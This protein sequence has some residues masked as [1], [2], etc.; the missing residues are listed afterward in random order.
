AWSGVVLAALGA[1]GAHV[2]RYRTSRTGP[3]SL[4]LLG[5]IVYA[6]ATIPWYLVP[7]SG[8]PLPFP[9]LVDA[10]FFLSYAVF[11]AAL[12]SLARR[13]RDHDPRASLEVVIVAIG[14][15]TPLWE[16][17]LKPEVVDQSWL[18]TATLYGYPLVLLVLFGMTI[19]L[20]LA[21]DRPD[22][23]GLL[24]IG[25]IVGELVADV[26]YAV[27]VAN[28][29]F[30]LDSPFLLLYLASYTCLG[31]AA[32]HPGSQLLAEVRPARVLRP[33]TRL[34]LLG[35]AVVS[36]L[37]VLAVAILRGA[38]HPAYLVLVAAVMVVLLLARVSSLMV[39]LAE[40]RRLR[41]E[42]Q[43]LAETLRHRAFHD[44]L[45]G[46]AN[47]ALFTEHIESALRQR[48]TA[49]ERGPAVVMLEIDGFKEINDT[50]GHDVGDLVLIAVA[51]RLDRVSRSGDTVARLGGDEFA[52]LLPAV[53][54]VQALGV[55]ERIVAG[56]REPLELGGNPV[57]VSTSIGIVVADGT[58]GRSQLLKQADVAMFDAK[59]SQR[60]SY[61]VFSPEQHTAVLKR[62]ALSLELKG[63]ASRG[64][65][66][67]DYQPVM[68]LATHAMVGVEAL[69]RWSHPEHGLL[70]PLQ[71]I[72]LAEAN[73]CIREIGDWVLEEACRQ[74][75]R[76]DDAHPTH[77][78]LD[79]AVNLSPR[80]LDAD[81]VIERIA[82]IV[83]RTGVEPGR[84]VLEL[85]ESALAEDTEG[86]I[87]KMVRLKS[88]GVQVA[89]DDFGTGFSSLSVLRR[90]PL[91]II[92]IDRTFVAG[93]ARE[94]EEWAVTTAIIALATSLGKR[95]LA[96][97][98]ELGEQLAHLRA[99][100]CELGQGYLFDRPLPSQGIDERLASASRPAV[101]S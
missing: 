2:L 27:S 26:Y 36:P 16:F 78:P 73:G 50:L 60:G 86:M 59:T 24:L 79:I 25:W 58:Q 44:A 76:W 71:F 85:T 28:G 38:P 51:E 9:S 90:L 33:R 62:H 63:A 34:L 56:F 68:E 69:V 17:V 6:A 74:S 45:T 7:A 53:E 64:E 84:V 87:A 94:P 20:V 93:I 12:V 10:G 70:P 42:L 46:L 47:R 100:Q 49:A 14:A 52:L 72:P 39:D 4:L 11:A 75:G 30:R 29:T 13:H 89:L 5:F 55:A 40:Q 101:R 35:S 21:V 61:R 83:Q 23:A 18:V 99:L 77:P 80:Q 3:W 66:R 1:L 22:G 92:K 65:L 98:I 81:D 15:G 43:H 88:L 54:L 57:V 19:R 97:G 37:V 91:D 95:T 48:P 31:A 32:L 96:E 8:H 82:A 67:L 41:L